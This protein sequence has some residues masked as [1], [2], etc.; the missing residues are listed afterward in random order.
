MHMKKQKAKSGGQRVTLTLQSNLCKVQSK[1]QFK[2]KYNRNLA[3]KL[4]SFFFFLTVQLIWT[5]CL[6]MSSGTAV[7]L[8]T[9]L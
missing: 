2:N 3:H 5:V 7:L 8:E 6:M 4:F 9:I 1:K